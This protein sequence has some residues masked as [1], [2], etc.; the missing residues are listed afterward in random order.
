M[1]L[2]GQS[3][4]VT[5]NEILLYCEE[6]ALYWHVNT[7]CQVKKSAL[8]IVNLC[9]FSL[10]IKVADPTSDIWPTATH[11]RQGHQLSQDKLSDLQRVYDR[12]VPA[13]RRLDVLPPLPERV[14]Q[15]TVAVNLALEPTVTSAL[16]QNH[17]LQLDRRKR[18]HDQ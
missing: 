9:T 5:I 14:T 12:Y 1:G 16:A 2:T 10:Y 3:S 6:F 15:E 11:D 18:R 17:M 8:I 13:D 7:S 4:I